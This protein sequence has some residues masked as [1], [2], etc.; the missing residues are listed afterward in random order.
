MRIFIFAAIVFAV[1]AASAQGGPD[2]FAREKRIA[3]TSYTSWTTTAGKSEIDDSP[4]VFLR[5]VA[6]SDVP[7]RF[8]GRTKPVLVLRC[9]ENTTSAYIRFDGLFMSDID[10]YGRVTFRVDKNKA[11]TNRLRVSTDNEALG[12]WSGGQ[13]IPFIKSL[14]G[15][16]RLV[17][18]ATPYGESTITFEIPI[19]GLSDEVKPLRQACNW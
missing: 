11:T 6:S 7:A 8:G 19:S 1:G 3:S 9:L 15:G 12:L 13:S 10:S 16:E 18:R 2:P 5:A 4:T 17:V 14:F